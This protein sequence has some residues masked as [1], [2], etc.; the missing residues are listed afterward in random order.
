MNRDVQPSEPAWLAVARA[1]KGF[2]PDDEGM[3]LHRAALRALERRPRTERTVVEVGAWCGKS[4]V[5]LGAAAA[6]RDGVV[7]SVDHH[8]GSEEQQAGWPH[9]DPEVV[10]PATGRIDTLPHFRRTIEQ[11]GLEGVVIAVVGDSPVVASLLRGPLAMCFIDGGHGKEPAWADYRSWSLLV[12]P[13][14]LLAIHDVFPDPEA[15]GRP[16][17]EIYCAALAS[18]TYRELS[19]LG[20]G[21]L[22]VLERV[23]P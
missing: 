8:R 4:T 12:A 1:A 9:H 20:C 10:D 7:L 11:A 23:R 3:A 14:G 22:K 17:Y 21:S 19:D 16:P 2:M 6:M 13:G 5:Y 18:G 15:G